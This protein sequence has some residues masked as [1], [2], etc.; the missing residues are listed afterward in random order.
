MINSDKYRFTKHEKDLIN[1][2]N[3]VYKYDNLN[4]FV[5][6]KY[7]LYVNILAGINKGI[8]KKTITE[9]YNKIPIKSKKDIN[10]DV[11]EICNIFNKEPD[12]FL[13]SI[14]NNLEKQILNG[15]IKNNKNEIINYI[16]KTFK[17]I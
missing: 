5:L 12:S 13:N 17:I 7:G 9:V 16:K 14:Y 8:S 15:N 3:V 2:V 1:K 10:I 11:K 6:Y 4:P